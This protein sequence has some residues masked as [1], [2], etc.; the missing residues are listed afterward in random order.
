MPIISH[1][2]ELLLKLN[3]CRT[4]CYGLLH[5]RLMVFPYSQLVSL[6][7]KHGLI[8]TPQSYAGGFKGNRDFGDSNGPPDGLADVAPKPA[9]LIA[10]Q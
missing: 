3:K 6:S 1:P 5:K 2:N 10:C 9:R 8:Y 7:V 4:D